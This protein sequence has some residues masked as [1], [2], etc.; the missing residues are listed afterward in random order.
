MGEDKYVK[1]WMIW[2]VIKKIRVVGMSVE[3]RR[4]WVKMMRLR[5]R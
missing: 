4:E 3:C 1:G 5:I 2:K